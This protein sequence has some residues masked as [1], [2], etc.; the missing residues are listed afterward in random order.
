[1]DDLKDLEISEKDANRAVQCCIYGAGIIGMLGLYGVIQERVM[2]V[3]YDGVMFKTSIFLVLCNRLW[4]ILYA[5]SMAMLKGE[6]LSN[7]APLWKYLAISMSNVAATTCQYEA[8]K[9]VSFPVQMLG[10]S[11]KMMP[12][13][14]WGIIISGKRYALKDWLIAGFVTGG[15][16][17]FLMTGPI[18]SKHSD[19][20]SSVYGLILL[21]AFLAID[22]FTSTFQEKLFKEHQTSK[23]NQMM[24]VNAGSAVVSLA[25]L[26]VS[27][28]LF[29]SI[30]FCTAHPAFLTHAMALSA[31]AVA[32]QFFIYSQVKEFGALVFA[33]TMN[34]RQVVS[35][36]NS[37]IIYGHEVGLYQVIGLVLVFG[38]LFY[39]SYLGLSSGAKAVPKKVREEAAG[40]DVEL[41]KS[42]KP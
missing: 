29:E 32:G 6:E 16:T 41:A 15:V 38:A 8:L 31:S 13:M 2:S 11:F 42:D 10:K 28:G 19:R 30:G 27:G 9:W 1:M 3:P 5:V 12:V 40:G 33:A 35:I 39:K 25:S 18:S 36:L 21:L 26:V 34:L 4:G 22:G 14:I 24:Y 23:Y 37:Y 20:G 7:K 17:M